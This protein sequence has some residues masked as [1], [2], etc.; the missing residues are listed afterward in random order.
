[1]THVIGIDPGT[2]CGFATCD[3]T[4][5]VVSCALDLSGPSGPDL[6]TLDGRLRWEIRHFRPGL[7]C[8]ER[9]GVASGLV[10]AHT[11]GM[12]VGVIRLACQD[13][14]TPWLECR[15][16]EWRAAAGLPSAAS[17]AAVM[18]AARRRWPGVTF[19]SHDEA[20]ARFIAEYGWKM[21][22]AR[23]GGGS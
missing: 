16:A 22:R 2:R 11:H 6:A 9:A 18:A 23:R 1:M 21:W 20:E 10:A 3:A 5:F 12:L 17:K 14:G 15:T 7:V 19:T 13:S 4:G 8:Y